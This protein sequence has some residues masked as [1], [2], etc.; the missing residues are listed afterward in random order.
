MVENNFQK[1]ENVLIN[2]AKIEGGF[3]KIYDFLS[4]KN[5][6]SKPVRLFWEGMREEEL[7]HARF[8]N[9]L[10]AKARKGQG[11]FMRAE[12]NLAQLK[13]FVK[14][15]NDSLETIKRGD[16]TEAEAYSFASNIESELDEVSFTKQLKMNDLQVQEKLESMNNDNKRHR[17]IM[18][19]R[20]RGIK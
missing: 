7:E 13:S 18:I 1:I 14:K 10:L 15:I 4:K 11:Y 5:S 12:I 17:M 9:E 6:F 20:S 2:L 19:N 8:F 3:A 16:L